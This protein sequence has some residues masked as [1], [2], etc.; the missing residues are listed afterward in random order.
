MRI[1]AWNKG[2]SGGGEAGVPRSLNSRLTAGPES[3]PKL[4]S[5]SQISCDILF[6]VNRRHPRSL[7]D[8]A[9]EID[10]W[11]GPGQVYLTP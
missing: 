3:G 7:I 4:I 1:S 5:E 10:I 8:I 9:D 2:V 11:N 6:S